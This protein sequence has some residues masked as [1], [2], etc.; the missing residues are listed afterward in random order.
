MSHQGSKLRA[1]TIIELLVVITIIGMLIG[2]L[3][4]AVQAARE[5]ARRGKCS[6]NLKQ[7]ALALHHY[8]D[9]YNA[10]PAGRAG[11]CHFQARLGYALFLT[12]YLERTDIYDAIYAYGAWVKTNLSDSPAYPSLE[13]RDMGI[14]AAMINPAAVPYCLDVLKVLAGP[15]PVFAC[16]SDGAALQPFLFSDQ[17]TNADPDVRS[18]LAALGT[19]AKFY[20]AKNSYVASMGDGMAGQNAFPGGMFSY[21]PVD[22]EIADVYNADTLTRG[23]FMPGV[24]YSFTTITDGVSNTVALSETMTAPVTGMYPTNEP[25]QVKGGVNYSG[26]GSGATSI[27]DARAPTLINPQACLATGKSVRD[28]RLIR[29]TPSNCFRGL[30]FYAGYSC[31]S[32]FNTVLA[33]N[34]PSCKAG[35]NDTFWGVYAAQSNHPGGVNA[36]MADGSVRFVS[37]HIDC[38]A[39][40]GVV[41][42]S[43][44]PTTIAE[45][46]RP[47]VHGESPYGVWGA[48]G[49]PSGG[50]SKSL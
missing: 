15:I 47:V 37:N 8:H 33:P 29:N 44:E 11:F 24:W 26:T 32:R 48:A 2:L 43:D 20:S 34:S 50:E 25:N 3:L 16:P 27:G 36:A 28:P 6:N 18:C 35:Q 30:M 40:G 13:C 45:P 38:T 10:F 39:G 4:P 1:F 42:L 19:D 41:N 12:P 21:D 17:G 9:A 31:D 7:I 23:L 46:H 5:A 14:A 22:L 49:T